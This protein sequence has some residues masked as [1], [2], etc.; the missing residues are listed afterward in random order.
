MMGHEKQ[1]VS[2]EIGNRSPVRPEQVK[3][4]LHSAYSIFGLVQCVC[5]LLTTDRKTT[6]FF[7]NSPRAQ[8]KK[9]KKTP[10]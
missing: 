6:N 5:T 8:E 3:A 10:K 9:K 7:K 2:F 1:L 4:E